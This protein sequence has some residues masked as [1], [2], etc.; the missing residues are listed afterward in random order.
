MMMILT[1]KSM[2]YRESSLI[3]VLVEVEVVVKV[4]FIVFQAQEET[5]AV[6][7]EE[8]EEVVLTEEEEE[9]DH[10]VVRKGK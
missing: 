2:V 8:E 6:Q 7:E 1:M 9:E 5:E 4:A 10:E 3:E